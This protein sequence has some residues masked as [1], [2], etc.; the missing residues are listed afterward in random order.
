MSR[1]NCLAFAW[2]LYWRQYK[3]GSL[4]F[5][6]VR[7]SHWGPF[8]HFLYLRLN[9]R[10]NRWRCVSFVPR[11]PLPRRI[12]PLLF[13]GRV[14]WGDPPHPVC[15]QER[16]EPDWQGMDA[17]FSEARAGDEALAAQPA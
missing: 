1:S 5:I 14:R 3:K 4:G 12:P 15:A 9:S 8:P 17:L 10:S 16:R 6:A 7:R 11:A 13:Q 2:A